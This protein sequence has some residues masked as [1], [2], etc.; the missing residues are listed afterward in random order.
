MNKN[1]SRYMVLL[2][3]FMFFLTGC[4]GGS[5]ASGGGPADTVIGGTAS[6]G[7]I[8]NGMVKIFA[9]NAGGSKTLLKTAMTN[10]E[11][12]YEVSIGKYQGPVMAEVSGDYLDEATGLIFTVFE[13]SPLRAAIAEAKGEVK[14]A[15]TPFTELALQMAETVALNMDEIDVANATVSGLF[16][17]D[18]VATQPRAPEATALDTAN[19]TEKDY[20]LALAALSQMSTDTGMTV[21]ELLNELNLELEVDG[22]LSWSSI[23]SFDAALAGFLD[24]NIHNHTG[25]NS[26]A[27][28]W[29]ETAFRTRSKVRLSISG[30]PAGIT[31]GGIELGLLLPAG[32]RPIEATIAATGD[33]TGSLLENFYSPESLTDSGAV[34]LALIN[35]AGFGA[36]EFVSIECESSGSTLPVADSFI[37]VDVV[38][39]DEEG[40]IVPGITIFAS[41]E[42]VTTN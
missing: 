11:G 10:G 33:V 41:V 27:G 39:V 26:S 3:A 21:F 17:F 40:S 16:G 14:I 2:I 20:T 4:G 9:L 13:D 1:I 8:V 38:A 31:L 24:T 19:V 42:A 5:S 23:D 25:V 18:I 37:L 35:V 6:K 12:K 28:S 15:V 30:L 22:E 34:N 7:I 32:V 36:G 29:L